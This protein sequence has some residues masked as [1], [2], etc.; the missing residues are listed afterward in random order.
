MSNWANVVCCNILEPTGSARSTYIPTHIHTHVYIYICGVQQNV[1]AGI[2]ARR[3]TD[4]LKIVSFSCILSFYHI[5]HGSVLLMPLPL[6]GSRLAWVRYFGANSMADNL[7]LGTGGHLPPRAPDRSKLRF[8]NPLTVS[9]KGTR[10][11]NNHRHGDT[12]CSVPA[13]GGR[14]A[15]RQ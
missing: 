10:M 2:N 4:W 8:L 11:E 15:L 5:G 13:Q 7:G 1:A 12:G 3:I 6:S 9:T 14:Y